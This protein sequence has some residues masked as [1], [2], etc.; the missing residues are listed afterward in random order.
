MNP[1]PKGKFRL[2]DIGRIA[3][4]HVKVTVSGKNSAV[5]EKTVTNHKKGK[6]VL[7]ITPNTPSENSMN[8]I[9]EPENKE[10]EQDSVYNSVE[11]METQEGELIFAV[12]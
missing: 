1:S 12:L 9:V 8:H 3:S 10:A 11:D 6:G 7:A 2:A 4:K 5:K